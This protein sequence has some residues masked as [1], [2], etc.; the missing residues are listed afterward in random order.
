MGGRAVLPPGPTPNDNQW[1]RVP[2]FKGKKY[3]FW[4]KL[5]EYNP[6]GE[7]PSEVLTTTTEIPFEEGDVVDPSS[8]LR[9]RIER[10][11]FP[12][13]QVHYSALSQPSAVWKDWVD[14]VLAS[15][16]YKRVLDRANILEIIKISRS[17]SLNKRNE[18]MDF[19]VSRWSR[20]T[21][22]FMFPWGDFGPTLQDT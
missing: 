6:I 17:F 22:T 1:R 10:G 14:A 9:L 8:I 11:D 18:N 2:Y 15:E 16:N 21:H 12:Y 13:S 3:P 20:D 4:Q 19:L 7:R 5:E